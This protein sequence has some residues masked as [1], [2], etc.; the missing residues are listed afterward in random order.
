[1]HSVA[2]LGAGSWGTALA[3][4]LG[5]S[6][7]EVR[8]WCRDPEAAARIHTA[9]RNERYLPGLPLPPSVRITADLDAALAGVDLAVVAVPTA[10]VRETLRRA[11]D[12]LPGKA[13]VALAAKGLERETG[14]RLSEVARE[15]L[16][17]EAAAR[18]AVLSGP[19]LAGEIVRRIPT[20]TVVA[21]PDEGL[22]RSL[23]QTFGTPH[24]RV[25][26]NA[27]VIGAELGGAL[28]NPISIAAGIS[29]G[30]GFGNNTK[31]SLL[32]RGLAEMVRLGMAAG[33]RPETFSGLAGLGDLIATA[34]SPLSRNYRLGLALGR[35]HSR[36]AAEASL[37]QVAEGVP[38]TE[39][40]CHLAARLE[41]EVPIIR[42][43]RHILYDG[44][45]AAEAV[46]ILL[47]RPHR[48]E[49]VGE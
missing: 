45:P 25:Y 12:L 47:A 16:G 39:A 37:H 38:T 34:S 49:G 44:K 46:A 15:E 30:L 21:S 11:R 5:E 6:G 3:W 26:T 33:A 43:L 20:A 22:A 48:D 1:M 8:L 28:K 14:K 17:P 27:D 40:A 31:A 4:L 24:F 13:G 32:T 35:G 7:R 36:E 19:N 23:Q 42:E 10:A 41:V 9:R 2:V 29:D 18:V